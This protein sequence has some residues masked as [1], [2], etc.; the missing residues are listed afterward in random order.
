M[1]CIFPLLL[2]FFLV[3]PSSADDCSK[4]VKLYNHATITD[5]LK[6]KE[7]CFKEAIPLCS[8][9]EIRSRIYNNLADT[10]E[11]TGRSSIALFYYKKALE[12]KSDLA[13]AY[14]SVGDIFFKVKDYYSAAVMYEKGLGYC[15]E[16]EESVER[17]KEA[18]EKAKN[19]T[20]IYFD[21]DSFRIPFR[22]LNR[23][24]VICAT[25]KERRH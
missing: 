21:F 5:D 14:F 3:T 6:V 17:W 20:I 8:D 24:D 18:L 9:S 13:T 10:Y 2:S 4:A 11:R 16:D 19:H 23:L 7:E 1:R 25:I 22:Y 15:L 12:N